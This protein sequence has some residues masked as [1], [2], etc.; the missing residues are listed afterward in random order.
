MSRVLTNST[1]LA[2]CIEASL[3]VLPGSP[4]W[5]TLEPNAIKKMGADIKTVAREPISSQ[6][7]RRKGTVTDLD[8]S[9]E[10]DADLTMEHFTDFIEGFVF[11]NGKGGAFFR[12][13][14][15]TSTGYTVASGGA[16]PAGTL[17]YARG[18]KTPANNGYKVV[19][20]SSTGTEVKVSG[21][22]AEASPPSNAILE[23]CGVRG[24]AGDFEIDSDG[25][26]ISTT[27]D[28]TTLGLTPGQAIYVGGQST[29]NQFF[30]TANKGFARARVIAANKIT[31]DKKSTVF[32]AD[33]GTSTGSGGS[34]KS[35]DILFGRFVR[36]VSV[37]DADYLERS[38]QFEA[39]YEDLISV[40]TDG[41]EYAKGNYANQLDFDLPITNKATMTFAFV[42]TDTPI[43]T[44]TRATNAASAKAPLRTTAF[45]TSAD[46]AR[47]RITKYDETGLTT[48]FKSLKLTINN[49]VSP[50]KVIG[51]LGARYLNTGIF[52]I[53][54]EA[55]VLFTNADVVTA[56]RNNETVTMDF[57]VR[58]DDG[59]IFVDIPSMTLGSGAKDFPVN[60]TVSLKTTAQA[61]LDNTFGT[62]IGVSTFPY[63]PA[64]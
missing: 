55:D 35:I 24:G 3:G 37:V 32:V 62:S 40:G 46:V 47:L 20:S 42:G 63:V 45:N 64:A 52:D 54:V 50:E 26:L 48:D 21:L 16:L 6:R 57:S 38:Y 33:D 4:A 60:Q 25:N 13:T 5:K 9:V 56:V 8:S 7:Q 10:L 11:A 53:A 51:V 17:V 19:G 44:S 49:N 61:F 12:P 22:T 39:T 28:F 43:P 30:N 1:G 31:L 23:V 2:Y 41:Y 27:L 14:A 36:N 58:N 34:D 59:A 15:V 29:A 18:F